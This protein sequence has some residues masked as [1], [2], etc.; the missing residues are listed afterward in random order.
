MHHE[1]IDIH[2]HYYPRDHLKL[3]QENI[4]VFV[5]GGRF[6]AMEKM[7]NIDI[8]LEEM[9]TAQITKQILSVGPPGVD[10]LDSVTALKEAKKCNDELAQV[11]QKNSDF[12]DAVAIL[13]LQEI[14]ESMDELHRA[15]SDLGLKGVMINSNISGKP[16][17]SPDFFPLYEKAGDLGIPLH[18]H[19]TVPICTDFMKEYNL[20]TMIG[21]LFDSSLQA[22]RLILSGVFDKFPKTQ[23]ILSHLGSLL[24][25]VK[26]R[27]DDQWTSYP[28][29]LKGSISIAPSNYLG[30]FFT[31]TVNNYPPSY[32]LAKQ[33]F[34]MNHILFGTDYPFIESK[35]CSDCVSNLNFSGEEMDM[36]FN[37]NA[38]KLFKI[39]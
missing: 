17:D 29:P 14:E 18:I 13:P 36:V 9:S 22:L 32:E 15:I 20:H 30:R 8:R 35:V 33:I 6:P 25:Y 23:F 16:L 2:A 5:K 7:Y 19:P 21:F 28:P 4:D 31:D 26:Q 27:L 10:R 24:P 12:F 11:V 1:R 37:T 39:S 3:I 38:R 34:G